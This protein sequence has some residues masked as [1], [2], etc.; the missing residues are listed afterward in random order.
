MLYTLGLYTNLGFK[1]HEKLLYTKPDTF[2]MFKLNSVLTIH[3]FLLE[4]LTYH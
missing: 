4:N 3:N 2:S 1:Y